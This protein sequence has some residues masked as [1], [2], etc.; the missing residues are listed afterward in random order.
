[1]S[2]VQITCPRSSRAEIG[3]DGR[4]ELHRSVNENRAFGFLRHR[5]SGRNSQ[6]QQKVKRKLEQG[7]PTGCIRGRSQQVFGLSTRCRLDRRHRE[8]FLWGWAL[9]LW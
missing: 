1:M 2:R 8:D 9:K 3:L 7:F 6:D 5:N 4:Q